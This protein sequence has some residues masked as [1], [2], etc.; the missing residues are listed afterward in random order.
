[1]VTR[2]KMLTESEKLA[3][4]AGVLDSDGC[5]GIYGNFQVRIDVAVKDEP[6]TKWI[7]ENF[8]GRLYRRH[9]TNPGQAEKL[10]GWVIGDAQATPLL[11]KIIPY[12]ILKERQG[13]VCLALRYQREFNGSRNRGTRQ[14]W[15]NEYYLA[16]ETL[17]RRL[18]GREQYPYEL[19][20]YVCSLAATS[21]R[22]GASLFERFA[23]PC[24]EL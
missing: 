5:I 18:N 21:K 15:L 19:M 16:C 6:I 13:L 22:G 7:F 8:G 10:F 14:E 20:Q 24:S 23:K 9:N 11:E 3:Y 1:M 2:G 17:I 4:L 12:L